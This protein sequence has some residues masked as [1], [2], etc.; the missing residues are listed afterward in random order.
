MLIYM[1]LLIGKNSNENIHD[2]INKLIQSF[3]DKK[4]WYGWFEKIIDNSR[5][6]ITNIRFHIEFEGPDN[7]KNS[8]TFFME[9]L[10]MSTLNSNNKTLFFQ[11]PNIL[12]KKINL[13]NFSIAFYT[14]VKGIKNF[15]ELKGMKY[16][17]MEKSSFSLTLKNDHRKETSFFNFLN[18]IFNSININI[19]EQQYLALKY[20]FNEYLKS[21]LYQ[22]FNISQKITTEN[23]TSWSYFNYCA[24]KKKYQH[25]FSPNFAL[26]FFQ[27][28]KKFS[29]KFQTT[30]KFG[31]TKNFIN[32]SLEENGT[33]LTYSLLFCSSIFVHLQKNERKSIVDL[34]M[35]SQNPIDFQIKFPQI[36]IHFENLFSLTIDTIGLS[37]KQQNKEC[38]LN[39]FI[40]DLLITDFLSQNSIF[41][42]VNND[43]NFI[44]FEYNFNN[45][46]KKLNVC[47]FKVDINS[48]FIKQLCQTFI[49]QENM[50]E[51]TLNQCIMILNPL[52]YQKLKIESKGF[53]INYIIGKEVTSHSIYCDINKFNLQNITENSIN[54]IPLFDIFSEIECQQIRVDESIISEK[55]TVECSKKGIVNQFNVSISN[56]QFNIDSKI[57]DIV[58]NVL[59]S[60]FNNI[61]IDFKNIYSL[62]SILINCSSISFN[63]NTGNDNFIFSI[64]NIKVNP[65]V[66]FNQIIIQN[67]NKNQM[68][69]VPSL[70]FNEWPIINTDIIDVKINSLDFIHFYDEIMWITNQVNKLS[71]S[72]IPDEI[73]KNNTTNI[74]FKSKE[75]KY[76]NDERKELYKLHNISII[77]DENF[78]VKIGSFELFNSYDEKVIFCEEEI[79]ITNKM[80]KSIN[81][82]IPDIRINIKF[83]EFN[84]IIHSIFTNENQNPDKNENLNEIWFSIPKL[85]VHIDDSITI[86]T[87]ELDIKYIISENPKLIFKLQIFNI[88]DM[89]IIKDLILQK[90]DFIFDIAISSTNLNLIDQNDKIFKYFSQVLNYQ[91]RQIDFNINI[92]KFNITE[93]INKLKAK[94]KNI[95]YSHNSS[96]SIGAI[97]ISSAKIGNLILNNINTFLIY[98]SIVFNDNENIETIFSLEKQKMIKPIK[99]NLTK[100]KTNIESIGIDYTQ[101]F[102]TELFNFYTNISKTFGIKYPISINVNKANI[103]NN[104]IQNDI[105]LSTITLEKNEEITEIKCQSI[106]LNK[107]IE[108]RK[109]DQ[110]SFNLIIQKTLLD[111]NISISQIDLYFEDDLIK[112]LTNIYSSNQ[113][114]NKANSFNINMKDVQTHFQFQKDH[115]LVIKFDSIID[116][117]NNVSKMLSITNLSVFFNNYKIG[118]Q[119]LP[120]LENFSFLLNFKNDKDKAFDYSLLEVE[121]GDIN[122]NVSIIDV[123]ELQ[124]VFEKVKYLLQSFFNE[125]I[126]SFIKERKKCLFPFSVK[127]SKITIKP[128]TISLCE[129]NRDSNLY[130]PIITIFI[131]NKSQ[132]FIILEKEKHFSMKF[133][134]SIKNINFSNGRSETLMNPTSFSIAYSDESNIS[135]GISNNNPIDFNLSKSSFLALIRFVD[136]FKIKDQ[137][138]FLKNESKSNYKPEYL[139]RNNLNKPIK[140]KYIGNLTK[141]ENEYHI[142]QGEEYPL[143]EFNDFTNIE[144][145]CNDI[146]ESFYPNNIVFPTYY[147]KISVSIAY[148]NLVKIIQFNPPL[149]IQNKLDF[150]LFIYTFDPNKKPILFC[151]LKPKFKYPF[152]RNYYWFSDYEIDDLNHTNF[153]ALF[154]MEECPNSIKIERKEINKFITFNVNIKYDHLSNTKVYQIIPS[155][156][157]KNLLPIPISFNL[158]NTK[159]EKINKDP[160]DLKMQEQIQINS[161]NHDI[162]SFSFSLCL[163]SI[164]FEK[165]T[166]IELNNDED[167]QLLASSENTAIKIQKT[168][169]INQR[170]IELF[171]P[172]IIFNRT[173][174]NNP[175]KFSNEN[176]TKFK[177]MQNSL[178]LYGLKAYFSTFQLIPFKLIIK[179]KFVLLELKKIS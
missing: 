102:I 9:S 65:F 122:I 126:N 64:S 162:K 26:K 96:Q 21:K 50:N 1:H 44:N 113:K 176:N 53:I 149:S 158:Y 7:T 116:I 37:L 153:P 140:V 14:N 20:L 45:E 46:I 25:S 66:E 142:H 32:K 22:K 39:L 144:F 145:T 62:N 80:I 117:K 98:N 130:Y 161:F 87:N 56:A 178:A 38:C 93:S 164:S 43:Q 52:L 90:N 132:N 175:I 10:E 54:D 138:L 89:I 115:D 157:I 86:E 3:E 172:C 11:K 84:D 61:N 27:K 68:I 103:K 174:E 159:N 35:L 92:K 152:T 108:D 119:F 137:V 94:L 110:N 55:F 15:E 129:E 166:L 29:Q 151:E 82:N 124:M 42:T 73:N 121:T 4:E 79:Q 146:N 168:S 5:I 179:I 165:P 95:R 59:Y 128:I 69:K 41:Q 8:I 173:K 143:P 83:D 136:K 12:I 100:I 88:N 109:K 40:H 63:I 58:S 24:L 133:T 150:P 139:I 107:C 97:Q 123:S 170:K 171:T 33:D 77:F 141:K 31:F 104:S 160:I 18:T 2:K 60:I 47:K 28:R 78:V 13:T 105:K 112:I 74:Q 156:V 76:V 17:L 118:T 134:I 155:F 99:L 71:K 75:I 67:S 125:K 72:F 48:S 154:N 36:N 49:D 135:F 106:F 127:E 101:I 120:L 169:K 57:T 70:S 148:K 91:E 30:L 51:N 16:N 163:S 81:I 23:K 85:S 167:I 111:T 19:N 177:I 34:L 114:I 6:E 147:N 131:Q